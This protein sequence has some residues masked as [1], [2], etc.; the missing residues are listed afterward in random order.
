MPNPPTIA[1]GGNAAWYRPSDDHVQI[2]ELNRFHS[3]DAYYATL[4]HELGRATGH[5]SRLNR[6]KVMGQIR[7]GSGEYGKEE[8]VA[9][10]TSPF[11]AATV[12]LDDRLFGDSASDID[13]WL[14]VLRADPKAVVLPQLRLNEQRTSSGVSSTH[15]E[16][17]LSLTV[18]L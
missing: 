17:I 9:E 11:C 10:L 15:I 4:F 16:H 8:L 2:P 6:S 13:G 18:R 14:S 3:P 1:E 7:F 12:S 5:E